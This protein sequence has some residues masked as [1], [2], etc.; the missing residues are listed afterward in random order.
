MRRRGK[1]RLS[2]QEISEGKNVKEKK[3]QKR[4]ISIQGKKKKKRKGRRESQIVPKD[5]LSLTSPCGRA[6]INTCIDTPRIFLR[7]DGM[8]NR[9]IGLKYAI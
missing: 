8:V 5:V 2:S 1:R 7:E 4:K 3:K 6:V 9:W